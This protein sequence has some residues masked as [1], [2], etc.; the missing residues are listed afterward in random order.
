MSDS[1]LPKDQLIN[2]IIH[3]GKATK[4][5]NATETYSE[6]LSMNGCELRPVPGSRD[7]NN[8]TNPKG[9]AFRSGAPVKGSKPYFVKK[10]QRIQY[11]RC[12]RKP[13]HI[14]TYREA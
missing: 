12:P 13:L 10:N 11:P 3:Q 14:N 2:Q 9:R 7:E 1:N 6:S 5:T 8:S 4:S